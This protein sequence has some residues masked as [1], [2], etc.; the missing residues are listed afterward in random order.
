LDLG[1]NKNVRREDDVEKASFNETKLE[2]NFT[3]DNH[4]K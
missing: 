4:P 2:E 1:K 3:S